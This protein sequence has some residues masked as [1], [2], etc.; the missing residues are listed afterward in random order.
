MPRPTVILRSSW[1]AIN[2]GDIGHTPGALH[3]I[4]THL[5]DVDVVLWPCDVSLD[6]DK[7]LTRWF[8]RVPIVKGRLDADGQPIEPE[9]RDLFDRADFMLHGS[10][11]GPVAR[12]DVAAW[13]RNTG[14][15][16]GIYGVTIEKMPPELKQ[17][18]THAAFTYCRD[19]VSLQ[20]IKDQGAACPIMEFVPD[21]TFGIHLRD[22]KTALAFLKEHDL[23]PGQF[24][25]AIPRLRYTPYHKYGKVKWT[26]EHIRMVES[27]N[28]ETKAADFAKLRDVIIAWVR[29]TGKKVLVCPEMTYQLDIMDE[30]VVDP[31]PADVKAKVVPRRT[32][33]L[34]DE[35]CSVYA[36]A[37][38]LVSMEMHSPIMAAA[39]GTPALHVRQPT[40]TCKGQMWADVGLGDWLFPIEEVTG[41]DIAKTLLAAHRDPAAA[42]AHVADAMAFVGER[43]A[44]SMA[45]LKAAL[46]L[47]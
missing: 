47:G 3:I 35:A 44:A 18:L 13:S 37:L 11:P 6:V 2:I 25:C 45:A 36:H 33:W 5:P 34:P 22:D 17:L 40:D 43:Q 15:P 32:Y 31:L 24:I 41:D 12:K 8:P 10:G 20:F 23:E 26:E 27:V 9:L 4:E 39:N 21:A 30:L 1:Q 42:R 14:K 29:E 16:Y 46:G 7:L 28:A 19:T 38:A